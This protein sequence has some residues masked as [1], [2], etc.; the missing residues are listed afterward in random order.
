M[1]SILQQIPGISQPQNKFLITLFLTILLVL[2]F[3]QLHES[4][5]L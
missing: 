1:E 5:S 2:W 4:Q 3:G